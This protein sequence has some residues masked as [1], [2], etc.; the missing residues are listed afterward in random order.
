[1]DSDSSRNKELILSFLTGLEAEDVLTPISMAQLIHI[2]DSYEHIIEIIKENPHSYYPVYDDGIDNI[3]GVLNIRNII[4]HQEDPFNFTH[5]LDQPFFISENKNLA[6]LLEEFKQKKSCFALVVDEHGSVRGVITKAD[7]LEALWDNGESPDEEINS[8]VQEIDD[9]F[10]IDTRM[11]IED[12]N[13]L[14]QIELECEDCDSVGGF[15]IEQFSYVPQIGEELQAMGLN[16]IVTKT[17][18]AKL[19]EVKIN[20]I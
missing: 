1:M 15:I 2:D 7:I 18:G 17:E 12:F 13:K 19:E 8:Y 3:V 9:S 20:R 11:P 6:E 5:L 14:F 10:I 4:T 16:I